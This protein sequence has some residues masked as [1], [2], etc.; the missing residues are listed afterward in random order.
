MSQSVSE[1]ASE[2]MFLFYIFLRFLW[3]GESCGG[4]E[5]KRKVFVRGG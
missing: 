4:E 3:V 2:R 5:E 1:R